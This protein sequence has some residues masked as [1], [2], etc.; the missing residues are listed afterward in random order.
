MI[1]CRKLNIF[2]LTPMRERERERKTYRY[3]GITGIALGISGREHG[4]HQHE[5]AND[6]STQSSTYSVTRLHMVGPSTILLVEW[7]LEALNQSCTAD[8]TQALRNYVCQSS[9]KRHLPCQEQPKCYSWVDVPTCSSSSSRC[10]NYH[11]K[12]LG[13]IFPLGSSCDQSSFPLRFFV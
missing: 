9:V 5:S 1:I 3:E 11:I 7:F 12:K 2:Y 6:F 10:K 13:H 8:G 4:V